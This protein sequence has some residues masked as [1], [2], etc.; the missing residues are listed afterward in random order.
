M[1]ERYTSKEM[2]AIWSDQNKFRKWLDVELAVLRIRERRGELPAG[3]AE[4]MNQK[5]YA[6]AKVASLINAREKEIGH[7]LNAFVEAIRV[8]LNN[9]GRIVDVA[10]FDAV[11]KRG[12]PEK[13]DHFF[14]EGMTSYDTEEPAMALLFIEA[15]HQLML[16]LDKARHALRELALAHKGTLMIG[17]THGQFAQPVTFGKR[18]LDWFGALTEARDMFEL[19]SNRLRVMK[20]SGAVGMYGTFGPDIEEAVATEL[21]LRVAKI[22]TQIVPLG[23]KAHHLASLALIACEVEKIARDLWLLSQSEIGEVQEPFGKKQKGSSAMPH[24]KNPITL[25]KLF[26]LPRVVRGHMLALYENVATAHERDISHSSVERVSIPD[27]YAYTEHMLLQLARIVSGLQVFPERMRQNLDATKEV[28]ASQ[29]V[30]DLLG[31]R[32]IPGE[33]AYRFVQKCAFLVREKSCTF[34]DAFLTADD[35]EV[36]FDLRR[37]IGRTEEF[38]Q[39]FDP[40]WWVR[41]EAVYYQRLGL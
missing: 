21:N 13:W 6:D 35:D 27:A 38:D 23:R 16:A 39:A 12:H 10:E 41:H 34:S 1:L 37:E 24:K 30:R 28:Y 19:T 7:D 11:L 26:G 9:G 33:T 18:C 2:G 17:R 29:A 22:A 32:G 3:T 36:P 8:E 14:H 25:E 40:E 4:S 5:T 15:D 20:L 31:S